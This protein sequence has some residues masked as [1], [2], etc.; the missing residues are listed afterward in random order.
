MQLNQPFH[1]MVKPIG[2]VCNLRCE[3]CFYLGKTGLYPEEKDFRMP[4]DVLEQYIKSYIEA[5]SGPTVSFAWQGGEPTL[6]GLAFFERVVE[7]QKQY[8]PDGWQCENSLQTNGILLDE[9]WCHFLHQH[10]FL[11]GLSLD[12]PPQLHDLYRRDPEGKGT[13]AQVIEA[14]RR[15][16]EH[17]V[18]FNILCVV[19]NANAEQPLA[20]YDFFKE[21]DC[22][23][24][25]FIPLVE[26]ENGRPSHRSVSG[27]QYGYFLTQIFNEWVRHDLG[28]IYVQMFES[29]VGSAAGM[30]AGVCVNSRYC[31]RF[32]AMEHNGDLYACDHY[33]VPSHKLGNIMADSMG[34]MV[35]SDAQ[36]GFGRDKFDALPQKCLDCAV[37]TM[38]FGGCPKDRLLQD[39][40]GR[41]RNVLCEGFF[42]FFSYIH[43]YMER[44]VQLLKKQAPPESMRKEAQAIYASLYSHVG[45]NDNCPCGS[46]RKYKKCC[47][48]G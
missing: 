12:G 11:V 38:C 4:D 32:L 16:Q 29:C 44:I 14:L 26:P 7:L 10:G 9:A 46:G 8:L 36:N 45:R 41:W 24:L 18:E 17:Q 21:M 33:V 5:Q 23:F 47:G 42:Q 34:E 39:E 22:G 6:M 15:M 30:G 35:N 28:D 19:N 25:Q 3:Y 43:P 31:G 27:S 48:R 13:S 1:I 40:D 2:A 37:L 20:V